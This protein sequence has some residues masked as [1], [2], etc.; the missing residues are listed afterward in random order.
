ML[1]HLFILAQAPAVDEIDITAGKVLAGMLVM[2]ALAGSVAMIAIWAVRLH[3]GTPVIP[4]AYRKPLRVPLPLMIVGL[5]LSLLMALLTAVGDDSMAAEKT[6]DGGVAQAESGDSVA[7][8]EEALDVEASEEAPVET[9]TSDEQPTIED[10]SGSDS[11]AEPEDA[12]SADTVDDEAAAGV[13]TE[14]QFIQIALDN[15]FVNGFL[16]TVFGLTIFAVQQTH[17][18]KVK[19]PD[20]VTYQSHA[21]TVPLAFGYDEGDDTNGYLSEDDSC[22]EDEPPPV[23]TLDYAA[24]PNP[25]LPPAASQ[26]SM[27]GTPTN[28]APPADS[29]EPWIPAVEIRFAFETFLAAYVPTSILRIAILMLQP[30][31]PSHPFLEMME[32]GVSWP[33]LLLIAIMAIITAPIVEELLYRV[34]I[35]GGLMQQRQLTAG[36]IISSIVFGFA[37]GFP[38]SIALLPLAFAI[39]YTYIRRRSYRTV[40]MVH[41][42]FNLFNMLIAGIAMF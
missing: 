42:F 27:W 4:V 29:A 32:N 39:G 19:N 34:T 13:W 28:T 8:G 31:A 20:D 2:G 41:F 5:L 21:A 6:E 12:D 17:S 24:P 36:W 33:I 3:S 26:S 25:F 23:D 14:E 16:F 40:V 10:E 1:R 30:E 15:M 37:H 11:D 9:P 18:R 7:P 38:D 22:I 35:L